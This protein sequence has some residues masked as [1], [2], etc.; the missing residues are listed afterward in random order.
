M[1]DRSQGGG[2]EHAVNRIVDTVGG[3]AGQAGAV[4]TTA[5]G[6]AESAAISDLYEIQAGRIAEDRAQSPA[7]REAA[8]KMIED[9][10]DSAT[11]LKAT[12]AASGAALAPAKLDT[13]RQKMIDH[14]NAAPADRFDK[15]YVEQQ[16]MAHQ[17][18]VTLMHQYRDQGKDARLRSFATEM[19]PIIEAHLER[20]KALEPA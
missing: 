2:L 18:A 3:I 1:N 14:L 15:T 8:S 17:E 9:H 13:R 4:L 19:S 16:V 6:F 5:E 20:M 12:R 11:K 7:V 10:T